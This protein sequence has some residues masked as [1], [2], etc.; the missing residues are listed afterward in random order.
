V[1]PIFLDLDTLKPLNIKIAGSRFD[2]HFNPSCCHASADGK[3]YTGWRSDTSPHVL[4]SMVLE[5][6]TLRVV[7]A[8]RD[9]GWA[10]PSADGK[11]LFTRF[12]MFTNDLK[13][14]GAKEDPGTRRC[15][16]AVHGNNYLSEGKIY[17]LGVEAPLGTTEL[18]AE[19]I[20]DRRTFLIPDA[21]AIVSIGVLKKDF[22]DKNADWLTIRKIVLREVAK[23][24]VKP[25]EIDYPTKAGLIPTVGKDA[26]S[27]AQA[28]QADKRAVATIGF[29]G[30]GSLHAVSDEGKVRVWS[31]QPPAYQKAIDIRD[32]EEAP[33]SVILQER[34][35]DLFGEGGD[36][37]L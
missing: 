31:V 33:Q 23:E 4:H 28:L 5:G 30:N 13:R 35:N 25:L 34:C 27:S 29:L 37:L 6:D 24:E 8:H 32:N 3:V 11:V 16:P 20:N 17:R 19:D 1:Q 7:E 21:R 36:P 14:I 12:G 9:C 10:V 2:L 22:R 18:S 15:L 26:V